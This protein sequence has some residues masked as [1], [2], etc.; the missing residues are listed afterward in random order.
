MDQIEKCRLAV[1]GSVVL[2]S[3]FIATCGGSET[4]SCGT[5]G[6]SSGAWLHIPLTSSQAAQ[7]NAT[8]TLCRNSECYDASLPLVPAVGSTGAALTFAATAPVVG[9]LAQNSDLSIVLDL[10]WHLAD[11]SQAQDNDRY[12]VTLTGLSA[13]TLLD[14][15]ATYQSVAPN[16]AGCPPVCSSVELT[17]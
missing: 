11:A 9:T 16:G 8:V 7:A 4:Q 2:V 1:L 6:C 12:V 17:P 15:L 3:L 13:T 10:E 5:V 14:K